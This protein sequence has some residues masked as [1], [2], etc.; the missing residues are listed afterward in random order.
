MRFLLLY[1]FVFNYIFIGYFNLSVVLTF[2]TLLLM[3]RIDKQRELS[4]H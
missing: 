1:F 3:K 2:E 4:S